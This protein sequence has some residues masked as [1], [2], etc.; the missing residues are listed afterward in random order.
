MLEKGWNDHYTYIGRPPMLKIHWLDP[1]A[2]D[3]EIGISAHM[4]FLNIVKCKELNF[5]ITE[6]IFSDNT[7][8]HQS[9]WHDFFWCMGNCC[10]FQDNHFWW[11]IWN[12]VLIIFFGYFLPNFFD[13]LLTDG[14]STVYV[15]MTDVIVILFVTTHVMADIIAMWLDG[16]WLMPIVTDVIVT[17]CFSGWWKPHVWD[18]WW[19]FFDCDRW[20]V[21]YGWLMLLSQW[22]MELPHIIGW[23]NNHVADGTTTCVAADVVVYCGNGI[24]TW[25]NGWCY[26]HLADG[27]AM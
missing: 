9:N 21:T 13:L 12:V 2:L 19:N 8:F 11:C 20:K 1:N 27:I 7:S 16:W 3:F 5:S 24:A 18:N 10:T 14:K 17:L 26:C 4:D 6:P 25:L 15:F 23:C 22:Q